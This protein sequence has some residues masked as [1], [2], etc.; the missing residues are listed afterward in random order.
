MD[1]LLT[2]AQAAEIL[3]CST[4][5]IYA[6]QRAGQL[7]MR[8]I[9]HRSVRVTEE[10]V[11]RLLADPEIIKQSGSKRRS[12]PSVAPIER[13]QHRRLRI[14]DA[15]K[16][17]GL[18]ENALYAMRARG[19]GPSYIKLGSRILYDTRELDAWLGANTHR[20]VLEQTG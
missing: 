9:G 7:E 6:L 5:K 13:P 2:L 11:R 14:P 3:E 1:K 15:A 4:Y 18:T 19:T 16:Y 10:S 12:S 17:I 8:K 20:S